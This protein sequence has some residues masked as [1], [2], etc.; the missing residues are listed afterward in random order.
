MVAQKN[1]V[2]DAKTGAEK[3]AQNKALWSEAVI[4][5]RFSSAAKKHGQTLLQ[6]NFKIA[7]MNV[8]SNDN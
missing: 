6:T 5:D 8:R 7:K 3:M 2:K 1:I 4:I